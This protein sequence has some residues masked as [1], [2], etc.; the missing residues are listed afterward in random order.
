MT[1]GVIGIVNSF[2]IPYQLKLSNNTTNPNLSI[3][4]L[5]TYKIEKPKFILLIYFNKQ[6]ENPNSY[7]QFLFRIIERQ[8]NREHKM[9]PK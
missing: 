8:N 7:R 9:L 6:I 3:S 5:P 4:P 1:E 2:T